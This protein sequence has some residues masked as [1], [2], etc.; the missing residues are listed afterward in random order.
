MDNITIHVN[1]Q[2]PGQLSIPEANLPED[3]ENSNRYMRFVYFID[4]EKKVAVVNIPEDTNHADREYYLRKVNWAAYQL[5]SL[6]EGAAHYS[7]SVI[8]NNKFNV[9]ALT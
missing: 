4:K 7:T 1:E 3:T 8:S 6:Y 9:E 5:F 2:L